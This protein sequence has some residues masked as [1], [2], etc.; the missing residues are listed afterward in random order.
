MPEWNGSAGQEAALQAMVESANDIIEKKG[1]G[2]CICDLFKQARY[3]AQDVYLKTRGMGSDARMDEQAREAALW[4]A[5]GIVDGVYSGDGTDGM[6][7]PND[8]V[9]NIVRGNEDPDDGALW[10]MVKRANAIKGTVSGRD[11]CELYRVARAASRRV[12]AR[13]IRINAAS[14][15]TPCADPAK[16]ERAACQAID[17]YLE[18]LDE[19]GAGRDSTEESPPG[20]RDRRRS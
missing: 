18:E 13:P 14:G 20:P 4:G 19:T 11:L 16:S 2:V 10:A 15:K 8:L 7:D 9:A 17:E 5:R 3:R 1:E 12:A 6:G